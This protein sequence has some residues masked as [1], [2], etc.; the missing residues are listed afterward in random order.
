MDMAKLYDDW[1]R[2]GLRSREAGPDMLLEPPRR[3]LT[4]TERRLIRARIRSFASRRDRA[5]TV[6]LPVTGGIVLVLWLLTILASDAPWAIVTGFWLVAGVVLG[7]WVRRD[8]AKPAGQFGN[9]V[10]GLESAL[11]RNEADVY[12]VRARSFAELEEIED[13]GAC[14]VFE[15]EG[16]RLLFITGQ[17]FY[18]AAKFP[19]LD[20]AIVYVLDEQGATVDMIVDK[21]GGKTA[22]ARTI[23]AAA[24][25]TLAVPD[26]LEVIEGRLEDI[27]ARIREGATRA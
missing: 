1:G 7:V 8:M 16:G 25:R 9:M 14:Y 10:S 26:H 4:A 19:S 22:P 17:E 27:E 23:G 18:G 5:A 20:F 24:K 21:R 2:C 12:D 13:E 6:A 3:P 15:L 11:R